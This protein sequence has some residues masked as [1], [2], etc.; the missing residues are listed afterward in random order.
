MS[1]NNR[2][3]SKRLQQR[4]AHAPFTVVGPVAISLRIAVRNEGEG[5]GGLLKFGSMNV[6]MGQRPGGKIESAD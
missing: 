3:V 1:I 4:V 2:C 6:C 5:V